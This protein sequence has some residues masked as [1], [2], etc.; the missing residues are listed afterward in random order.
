MIDINLIRQ[1]PEAVRTALLKRMDELSFDELL[2]W[3]QQRRDLIAGV[4][5]CVLLILLTIVFVE[6]IYMFGLAPGM[7]T[8]LAFGKRL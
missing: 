1:D 7:E 3:D 2:G 6:A 5:F 8:L 4:G